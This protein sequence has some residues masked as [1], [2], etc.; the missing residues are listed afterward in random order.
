MSDVRCLEGCRMSDGNSTASPSRVSQ[1][2]DK[3][4]LQFRTRMPFSC[5]SV[6]GLSARWWFTC[7][8]KLA[9]LT[10]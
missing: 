3:E 7:K 6:A 10:L 5:L 9:Q 8:A 1:A 4:I 2:F